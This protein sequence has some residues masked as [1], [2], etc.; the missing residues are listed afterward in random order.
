MENKKIDYFGFLPRKW[1]I[2][3]DN[4]KILPLDDYDE[5]KNYI[6]KCKNNKAGFL[7]P[8]I[9]CEGSWDI[10]TNKIEKKIK[11]KQQP[12]SLYKTFMSHS[13]IID[14]LTTINED[15]NGQAAFIIH[16]LGYLCGT[17][18]QF[19]NWW[20]DMRIKI[21]KNAG[22]C[23][24]NEKTAED[25]VKHSFFIWK[26]WNKSNQ[27]LI[28]NIL[29]MFSRSTSYKWSWEQFMINYMVFD[30]LF[31]ICKNQDNKIKDIAHGKR[32]KCLCDKFEIMYKKEI[33]TEIV[34]LRNK[35]FHETLWGNEYSASCSS[36]YRKY[37]FYLHKLNECLIPAVLGYNNDYAKRNWFSHT[38]CPFKI[39]K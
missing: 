36:K 28:I 14:S 21:K 9:S 24:I 26:S 8:P 32:L 23:C 4:V 31:N 33:I 13:L 18:L 19:Q 11:T 12:A 38:N 16:L 22:I 30:G 1:S 27:H 34:N 20:I 2:I 5:A 39:A 15:R 37:V 6:E 3:F 7:Y 10:K 25:F 29:F 35:L 17:R